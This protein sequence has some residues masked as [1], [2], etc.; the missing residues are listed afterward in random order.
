MAK[1]EKEI[2]PLWGGRFKSG[3]DDLA[4]SFSASID[5]DKR[6]FEVDIQ[7]SIAYAEI[8]NVA[9]LINSSELKKIKKGL[10][11][12]LDEIKR[13]K[14]D[15]DSSLEDIHMNIEAKLVKIA[16]TAAKKIHTGRSRN[17][18]VATD[19]RLFLKNQIDEILN[20]TILLQKSLLKKA[21][22][23][24]DTLMPGLTHLQIAQPVTFGHHLMAWFEMLSRD[25]SRL[26]DAKKR[27]D[28][29][30]LGSAALSGTRFNIDRKFLAKKLGFGEISRNSMDA[31][32]DRDFVLELASSLSI[33][34]IHLSRICEEIIIWSSSQ[35]SYIY[36]S[37]EVC[38]GSS[39]MPQK[40]NPDMAELIRGG[41]S[42]TIANLMGL[43]SLMKNL[44]LTYNRDLQDDKEYIFSSIDF[45]KDSLKLL[46]L[47]VDGMQPN[48]EK[49][50]SDC[51]TGQITATDLADYLVEK[52]IAFRKAHEIVG[53]IVAHAEKKKVQ[54][55]E[56]E[57]SDLKKFSKIINEDVAN[58]LDPQ[59]TILSRKQVGG[60][61]PS[62][63]KKEIKIAKKELIRKQS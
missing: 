34:G 33:I 58:Y 8:L 23:N 48:V 26:E 50:K 52:G 60:T 46:S 13:D 36:L 16:G 56:L 9:N 2:N 15:W 7:G 62:Q 1:K 55:F 27:M 44:P 45:T 12:I 25:Y 5:I 57:I 37:D 6:L 19:L 24:T 22:E 51:F 61:A 54:I 40:K 31:V 30:P 3:T 11:K 35:Y 63:V 43:L 17:D 28:V 59:K 20:L 18:Q 10:N 14:F 42:K 32:S 21:D 47:I 41:A 39:I 49:M 4:Q 38:T 29:M 53:K